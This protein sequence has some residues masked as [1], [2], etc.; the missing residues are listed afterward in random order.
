MNKKAINKKWEEYL[1]LTQDIHNIVEASKP[2]FFGCVENKKLTKKEKKEEFTRQERENEL[3]FE[4]NG[5]VVMNLDYYFFL[6]FFG[7]EKVDLGTKKKPDI[8]QTGCYNLEIT[9]GKPFKEWL[10]EL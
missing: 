10:E 1:K 2:T 3:L 6:K 8:R 4:K 7:K 5:A 9:G